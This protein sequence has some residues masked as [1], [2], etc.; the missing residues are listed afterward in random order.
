MTIT[1][2][3][4]TGLRGAGVPYVLTMNQGETY[5]LQNTAPEPSDLSGTSIT[6]FFGRKSVPKAISFER[7]MFWERC[8]RNSSTYR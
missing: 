1:P 5:L 3:V 4:T 6:G 8:D 7:F 2:S